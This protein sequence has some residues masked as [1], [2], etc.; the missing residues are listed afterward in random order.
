[1]SFLAPLFLLGVAAVAWPILFHLIRRTSRE[2]VTF[3]SLMFLS[4]TPPRVTRRS[5][6]ENIFLLI[7]R[8]LVLGLLAF[9]FARPFMR[10]PIVAGPDPKTVRQII[11]LVDTSA[12]MRRQNLWAAARAKAEE[13]L[14]KVSP[15]D[16]V[17][18]FAFD[19]QPRTL[20]SFEQ[21][22]T[23]AV[24][25][26]IALAI[27]RL[28]ELTPGWS[29]TH[30]GQALTAAAETFEDV[31]PEEGSA[32]RQIVVV[33][34]LQEGSHL[35][36]LQGYEWP[37]GVEIAIEQVKSKKTTNAGLQLVTEIDDAVQAT[38]E[39]GPRIRASNA[40]DSKREEFKVR[41]AGSSEGTPPLELYIPPGQSRTVAAPPLPATGTND[42]L[43][44]L[45]DDDE[46]DNTV[47]Y[48]PPKAEE[49]RVLYLGNEAEIDHTQP[50]YYLKRAFQTTR[51][52][53]VQL[54]VRRPDAVWSTNEAA[55]AHLMI[56]ADPLFD[57]ALQFAREFLAARKT[58]LIVMKNISVAQTI[59]QLTGV[60]GVAAEEVAGERY[61]M[62]GEVKFDHPLFAPFADPRFSDFTKIHF[63]K[64]RRVV[65]E[66][67]PGAR[68]LARLDNGNPALIES[69][70]GHGSLLVLCA[71]WQPADSQ[72]ALS[73]K[74]V[75]LLYS[76]LELSGS[77]KPQRS[78]FRVDDE[79]SLAAT[80]RAPSI[81]VRKP[82]GAQVELAAGSR[83]SQTDLP[84]VYAIASLP[85]LQVAVNLD[86]AES[87]TASLALEELER[88]GLPLKQEVA[89]QSS[90]QAEKKR[91][92]LLA[93]ELENQ[94]RLWRW[95]LLA[96]F[97]IVILE[98]LI[99]GLVT[100]RATTQVE[101]A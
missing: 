36:G 42:H 61:T 87:K 82:D 65:A 40:A 64:H 47:Y 96:A 46:F 22:K 99:A 7:L 74:F 60:A 66:Q 54:L 35:D 75:P 18:V 14:R 58:V 17:A 56:V 90:R 86:P 8:C 16:R 12:S 45:G 51:R 78:Q 84:G 30:L 37:R 49:V 41:W 43:L 19:R 57:P 4:P 31:P 13:V 69:S 55:A 5:R 73:S 70:A 62:F 91:Q 25:E 67:I 48:V 23:M 1:M 94:Q 24:H 3:S 2:R 50:L 28:G 72:L 76:L 34:D 9:G 10:K 52:Q 32:Q 38:N 29:S 85:A 44:L 77:L 53:A 11:L 6:L 81:T 79:I 95:F 100:R 39:L 98:T 21:W 71:G 68:I 15:T 101:S 89:K 33:S 63:W 20:L 88:L 80:N 83:F 27:Q 97:G 26:R 93:T 59:A 92:H